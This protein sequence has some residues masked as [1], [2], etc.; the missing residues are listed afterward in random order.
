M[1]RTRNIG[2]TL[3]LALVAALPVLAEDKAKPAAPP[4]MSAEQKA[5]M[6]AYM[7]A[8]TPGAPHAAMAKQ[9]GEYDLTVTSWDAPGAPPTTDQ[10]TASRKMALD[11]RV[12]VEMMQG[13]NHGQPFSG[14][15]MRGYDNVSGKYWG[16]WNDSMS[17]GVMVSEGTCDDK[18]ACTFKGSWNDPVSKKPINARMTTRWTDASTEEFEMYAPGPDGKEMK[19]MAITYKKK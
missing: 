10:G 4:A 18:G 1:S 14:H 11:G 6:E 9:A 7:A 2:I 13:T 15:G 5:M 8:G 12:M 17:T 19:M 16:T 3:T